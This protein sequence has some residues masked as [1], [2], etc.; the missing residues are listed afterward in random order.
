[1]LGGFPHD[2]PARGAKG[3][4]ARPTSNVVVSIESG[5]GGFASNAPDDV[6]GALSPALA[7]AS[8]AEL[9]RRHLVFPRL[10]GVE[11]EKLTRAHAGLAVDISVMRVPVARE[12]RAAGPAHEAATRTRHLVASL[13]FFYAL[14]T[15]WTRSTVASDVRRGRGVGHLFSERT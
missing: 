12:F 14:T 9:Q 11:I 10:H 2:P 15:V 1:M 7:A 4:V 13:G 5:V 8:T 3:G 6:G